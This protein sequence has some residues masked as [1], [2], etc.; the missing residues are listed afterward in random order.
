MQWKCFGAWG[1]VKYRILTKV[2]TQVSSQWRRKRPVWKY[3]PTYLPTY[4]KKNGK[5]QRVLTRNF[6]SVKIDNYIPCTTDSESNKT[7]DLNDLRLRKTT[8]TTSIKIAKSCCERIL[9]LQTLHFK[10]RSP[11]IFICSR[12]LFWNCLRVPKLRPR[13][14]RNRD[15]SFEERV[16]EIW[17]FAASLRVDGH[18]SLLAPGRAIKVL[19]TGKSL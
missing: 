11:Q 1:P 13:A 17:S 6:N 3:L 5:R 2:S 8:K 4:R 7:K 16:F 10:A 19:A 18:P 15:L 9:I 12:V 14:W